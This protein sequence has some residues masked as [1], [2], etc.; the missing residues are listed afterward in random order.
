MCDTFSSNGMLNYSL[1][2]PLNPTDKDFIF[3]CIKLCNNDVLKIIIPLFMWLKNSFSSLILVSSI[4]AHFSRCRCA[5]CCCCCRLY[6]EKEEIIWHENVLKLY[7]MRWAWVW[8]GCLAN[9]INSGA[10]WFLEVIFFFVVVL[11]IVIF[12]SGD[13]N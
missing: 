12:I 7:L 13:S 9:I 4:D 11:W 3:V 2:D 8:I 6:C 10:E 5:L 1:N